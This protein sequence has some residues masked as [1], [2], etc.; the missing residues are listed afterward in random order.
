MTEQRYLKVLFLCIAAWVGVFIAFTWTINPYGVSPVTVTLQGINAIKPKRL[1]IDR[2][3]KPY[4]V[5]RYQ[6][7]TVFLGT[8]R[9]HQSVDPAV[10][11]G[12]RYAPAYNASIPASSLGMNIAHL[13]QYM[14]IDRNLQTV[15][16]ELFLY[17][18]LGQGQERIVKTRGEFI[19]NIVTLLGSADALRDSVITLIYNVFVGRPVYEITPGGYFYYPP[20]HDAQGTFQGYPAG[21]WDMHAMVAGNPKLHEPA[22]ES[23]RKIVALARKNG[24]ELAFLATPNHAYSDY[25]IDVIDRWDLVE[26]WLTK[27]SA[28]ATVY[29]FSQPNAWTYEPVGPRMRYWNDPF[30][31][32]LIMGNAMLASVAGRPPADAPQNF[33]VRLTPEM[34]PAHIEARRQAIRRWAAEN[35]TF[36]TRMD[37]ERRKKFSEKEPAKS[38]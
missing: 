6:P 19:S 28:E 16:V 29:S 20:G 14:E 30:H 1:D 5:W 4:E 9:I 17:N 31:A 33:M 22:F 38:K 26:D 36:V 13:R 35:K 27:L 23:F 34:V 24:I 7:K 21:I 11:D 32:S 15:F 37:E 8:S 12:T 2:L 25:Y 3:I 10:L 18:F